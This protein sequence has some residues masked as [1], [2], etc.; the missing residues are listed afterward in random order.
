MGIRIS[1]NSNNTGRAST[2]LKHVI[3]NPGK[4][5]VAYEAIDNDDPYDTTVANKRISSSI[6]SSIEELSTQQPEENTESTKYLQQYEG[7]YED[8]QPEVKPFD[9]ESTGT[10]GYSSYDYISSLNSYTGKRLHSEFRA[11]VKKGLNEDDQR[12]ILNKFRYIKGEID[13]EILI[14]YFLQDDYFTNDDLE[15]ISSSK[16]RHIQVVNFLLKLLRLKPEAYQDFLKYLKEAGYEHV[17]DI[18]EE[19]FYILALNHEN[20]TTTAAQVRLTSFRD[21]FIDQLEPGEVADI[22][23]EYEEFS[24]DEYEEIMAENTR[25]AKSKCIHRLLMQ[26]EHTHR[27]YLVLM[28]A[29]KETDRLYL[30]DL[31][32]QGH[33]TNQLSAPREK[34]PV[35]VRSN[36]VVKK[37]TKRT[38]KMLKESDQCQLLL[39]I[40]SDEEIKRLEIDK[41]KEMNSC[42][43]MIS[44][45]DELILDK[46]C[47]I[48]KVE[49]GS[50]IITLKG[51]GQYSLR[52]MFAKGVQG[53]L[54]D[55]LRH[56]FL[57]PNI[58]KLIP[59]KGLEFELTLKCLP[60]EQHTE[61]KSNSDLVIT[62]IWNFFWRSW[63]L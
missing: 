7:I 16:P 33:E 19:P 39:K 14:D 36:K 59:K 6:N 46:E 44:L 57:L 2:A 45:N 21:E 38:T 63:M 60:P 9:R 56:I 11:S 5:D 10:S 41:T 20:I 3:N 18:L 26:P 15:D 17:C 37:E 62:H 34:C 48:T 28:Q 58:R 40:Q 12:K 61:R 30:L 53:P 32:Q 52:R 4:T 31:F 35:N 47:L 22:F 55:I 29:L 23:L 42:V 25:R 24:V 1:S 54:T 49:Q 43:M 51:C 8:T 13:A 50:I 27:G